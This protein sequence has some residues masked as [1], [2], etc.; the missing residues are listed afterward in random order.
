MDSARSGRPAP[1]PEAAAVW[2]W[3]EGLEEEER[4]TALEISDPC[5]TLTALAILERASYSASTSP[6]A[7]SASF[8]FAFTEDPPRPPGAPN[9]S[10]RPDADS[11]PDPFQDA[12]RA[13][14]TPGKGPAPSVG[15][16]EGELSEKRIE[17]LREELLRAGGN[18]DTVEKLVDK[19]RAKASSSAAPPLPPAAAASSG[20]LGGG[21]AKEGGAAQGD[22]P[23][24]ENAGRGA[25]KEG[26]AAAG[27]RKGAAGAVSEVERAAF[28]E[29]GPLPRELDAAGARGRRV[30]AAGRGK[31]VWPRARDFVVVRV[32]L[33]GGGVE[34][35][36][37]SLPCMAF[38]ARGEELERDQE[39]LLCALVTRGAG[40]G[41]GGRV[42]VA[43]AAVRAPRALL[44]IM[45]RISR[46]A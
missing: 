16:G 6:R 21:H 43:R 18:R 24:V 19:L 17:L 23:G 9:A 36:A 8:R 29:A 28:G 41:E 5:F 15:P 42:G 7:A 2:R 38:S 32:E 34:A 39:Q 30:A 37:R 45:H 1:A 44:G 22:A 35:R 20:E 27:A 31:G 46:I 11:K 4:C 13:P 3:F 25:K 40:G 12:P 26:G 10:R 14:S 33:D